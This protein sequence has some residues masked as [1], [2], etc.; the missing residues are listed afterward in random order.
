MELP[1]ELKP[2]DFPENERYQQL[3]WQVLKSGK[4]SEMKAAELLDITVETLR[5]CRQDAEIYAIS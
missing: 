2:E 1:P 3:I 4:I 5:V